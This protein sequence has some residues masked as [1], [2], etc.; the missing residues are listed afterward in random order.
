MT[1]SNGLVKALVGAT[2]VTGMGLA[3][4]LL[5]NDQSY[6]SETIADAMV[7]YGGL[8]MVGTGLAAGLLHALNRDGGKKK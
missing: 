2:A 7:K 1:E 5:T 4:K 8:T 3:Y 6:M